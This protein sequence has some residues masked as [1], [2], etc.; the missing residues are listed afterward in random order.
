MLAAWCKG[1]EGQELL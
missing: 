1:T